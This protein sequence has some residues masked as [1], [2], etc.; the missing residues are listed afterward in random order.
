MTESGLEMPPDHIVSQMLSILDLSSP[1]IMDVP[2]L[3]RSGART[4][5]AAST[6][7][8]VGSTS[9]LTQYSGAS[10]FS[11]FTMLVAMEW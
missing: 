3:S 4:A 11:T 8:A 6:S 5:A 2:L 9:G 7:Y 1:V 10:P